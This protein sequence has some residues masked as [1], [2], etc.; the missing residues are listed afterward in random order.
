MIE[1][2]DD[3]IPW[4]ADSRQQGTVAA[5]RAASYGSAAPGCTLRVVGRASKLTKYWRY[6]LTAAG[7]CN[8]ECPVA[9][10]TGRQSCR[11]AVSCSSPI[12]TTQTP[13][14]VSWRRPPT[15]I[16]W[17]EA[18]ASADD[19]SSDRV[20]WLSWLS[21]MTR[22]WLLLMTGLDTT[23]TCWTNSLSSCCLDPS[24]ITSIFL[25]FSLR[26]LELIQALTWQ[27][28]SCSLITPD[29][30]LLTVLAME[31]WESSA[32]WCNIR[33]C[34]VTTLLSSAVYST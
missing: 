13:A 16:W 7:A 20:R 1:A 32:Y 19:S 18:S 2:C 6:V 28:H 12:G 11:R 8:S 14:P 17:L 22:K 24:H 10:G 21:I 9:V 26:R 15:V 4:W 5:D 29:D 27:R 31:I 23:V 34:T 25:W 30:A 33:P 3:R